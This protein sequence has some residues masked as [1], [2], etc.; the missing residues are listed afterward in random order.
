MNFMFPALRPMPE[1]NGICLL[2]ITGKN[3]EHIGS[4]RH[5]AFRQ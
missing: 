3:Y 1:C 2:D 4:V 5:S